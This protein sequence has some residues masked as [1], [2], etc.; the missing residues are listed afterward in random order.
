LAPSEAL[1]TLCEI[2]PVAA[3]CSSTATETAVAQLSISCM[4]PEMRLIADTALEVAACT[5]MISLEISSVALAV[6]TASD[7]T[8]EATTA[9]PLPASPARAAS[10]VALS[11]RRLVCPAMAR[12]NLITSP[13]FCAARASAVI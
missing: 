5:A 3:P 11:A 7:L 2:S 12:I 1:A 9:K 4:R 6:C 8:S 13:I 10:M